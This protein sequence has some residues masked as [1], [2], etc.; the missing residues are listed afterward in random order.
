MH[1]LRCWEGSARWY[2]VYLGAGLGLTWAFRVALGFMHWQ[3]RCTSRSGVLL[4]SQS[5]TVQLVTAERCLVDLPGLF[6]AS[7]CFQLSILLDE[8]L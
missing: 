7:N 5:L 2:P 6:E 3:F 8:K 4:L 1:C